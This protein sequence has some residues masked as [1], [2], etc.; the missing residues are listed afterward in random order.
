MT[1]LEAQMT[2]R[3][4]WDEQTAAGMKYVRACRN[5]EKR[6]YGLMYLAFL[7]SSRVEPDTLM[8]NLTYMG[9]QSV[10]MALAS[11]VKVAR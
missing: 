5:A 2:A 10:R 4:N 8:F 1:T 7:V 9:A 11:I 3:A 6:S